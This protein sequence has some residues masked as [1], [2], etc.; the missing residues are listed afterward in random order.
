MAGQARANDVAVPGLI[1]PYMDLASERW[2]SLTRVWRALTSFSSRAFS[3]ME[4]IAGSPDLSFLPLVLKPL[5]VAPAFDQYSAARALAGARRHG[6]VPVT[7]C[8]PRP[9][10][11][12][13]PSR[14]WGM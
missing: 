2:M 10:Y 6:V 5:K 11:W 1:R 12:P 7:V 13:W 9:S 3:I 8:Q 4:S 14:I